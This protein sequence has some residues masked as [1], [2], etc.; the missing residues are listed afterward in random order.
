MYLRTIGR[1]FLQ[2]LLV[3]SLLCGAGSAF[4]ADS[5]KGQVMGGGSPI[6]NRR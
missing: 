3:V 5:I 2:G 4:A 1:S 6:A